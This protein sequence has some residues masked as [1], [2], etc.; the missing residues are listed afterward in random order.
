MKTPFSKD[1][2]PTAATPDDQM[3]LTEHL[4]ELRVRIIRALLA[5]TIGIVV[6]II[7]SDSMKQ[8]RIR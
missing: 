2:R 6:I 8:P 3:T 7:D 4:A 5:V 1:D